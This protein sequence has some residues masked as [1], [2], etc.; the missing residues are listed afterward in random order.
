MHGVQNTLPRVTPEVRYAPWFLVPFLAM[1]QYNLLSCFEQLL[2]FFSFSLS[3]HFSRF[4]VT[5]QNN[6]TT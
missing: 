3:P 2:L 4:G 5:C 1:R 6:L